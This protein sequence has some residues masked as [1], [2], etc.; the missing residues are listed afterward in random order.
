MTIKLTKK[1]KNLIDNIEKTTGIVLKN[2]ISFSNR[3][4]FSFYTHELNEHSIRKIEHYGR[5]YGNFNVVPGGCKQ[6]IIIG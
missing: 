6:L 4:I 3:K 5:M 1:Q 2:S